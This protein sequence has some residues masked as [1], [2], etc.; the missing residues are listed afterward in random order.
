MAIRGAAR[1]PQDK[2]LQKKADRLSYYTHTDDIVSLVSMEPH[3][4]SPWLSQLT[5]AN[6]CLYLSLGSAFHLR[7][8][9]GAYLMGMIMDRIPLPHFWKRGIAVNKAKIFQGLACPGDELEMALSSN[10]I[11]TGIAG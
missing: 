7:I 5:V 10:H 3:F 8:Q 4:S 9:I 6:C 1:E 2:Q 11:V